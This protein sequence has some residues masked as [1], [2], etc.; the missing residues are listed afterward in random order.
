M[1]TNLQFIKSVSGTS[2]NTLSV[3]DC[4]SADYDVYYVSVNKG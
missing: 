3:T 4:F 1:A 2:V